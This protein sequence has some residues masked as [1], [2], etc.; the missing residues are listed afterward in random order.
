[1]ETKWLLDLQV[2][3]HRG[4]PVKI[5]SHPVMSEDAISYFDSIL[6]KDWLAFELGSGGSTI[7]LAKRVMQVISVENDEHWFEAVGQVLIQESLTNADLRLISLKPEDPL[8]SWAGY[9][10]SILKF[11]HD[12]F[13]LVFVDGWDP[14]RV[15]CVGYAIPKLKPGGWL[16]VDDTTQ[17]YIYDIFSLVEKW[18]RVDK[19]GITLGR[20]DGAVTAQQT[21][22]FRKPG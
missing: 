7:W 1:M 4:Y 15:P 21:S 16:V 12:Y 22:F 3:D 8:F 20:T 14:C 6:E 13:D 18:S 11:K 2:A 9:A 17:P 5:P 10:Q 19:S